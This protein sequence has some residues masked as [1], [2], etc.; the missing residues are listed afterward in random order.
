M[1]QNVYTIRA[2]TDSQGALEDM[3]V[4]ALEHIEDGGYRYGSVDVP[5]KY[6]RDDLNAA[7]IE[8]EATWAQRFSSETGI[9]ARY[10]NGTWRFTRGEEFDGRNG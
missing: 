6:V 10:D 7:S 9:E 1:S 2:R 4:A 5:Q 3:I 8:E